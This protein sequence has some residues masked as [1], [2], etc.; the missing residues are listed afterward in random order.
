MKEIGSEFWDIPVGGKTISFPPGTEYFLSG[1]A[2]LSHIIN[3]IKATGRIESVLLPSYLCET[4]ITPFTREGITVKTYPV[5]AENGRLKK[6]LPD[7]CDAD[8]VL[9]MDYFGF[10]SEYAAPE[11]SCTV[12]RDMTHSV[13][14]E[15]PDDAGY[16]YGS[17]RKW[18]G[19]YTGG[20]AWKKNSE[21]FSIPMTEGI[22]EEFV[23]LRREAMDMKWEFLQGKRGDKQY[24][25]TFAR[26]EKALDANPFGMADVEDLINITML[27][28]EK[29]KTK[30]RKNAALI[31]SRLSDY[32][33]FDTLHDNDCPLFVPVLLP[34]QK[35]DALRNYLIENRVYCPVHW[36]VPGSIE[37]SDGERLLYDC[38]LSLICDQRYDEEDILREIQLIE[39][40]I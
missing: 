25:E 9:L 34:K 4:M 37:L 3:D 1:R 16:S 11:Y 20:F 2:A 29:I 13:F 23:S 30:R 15:I 39:S 32:T 19:F 8:A 6:D 38:E 18:A 22:N 10:A 5:Y 35:R 40:F 14:T 21:S 7:K 36:P 31:M 17:L 27:D 24:L 26:A 33:M 28:A 12:I